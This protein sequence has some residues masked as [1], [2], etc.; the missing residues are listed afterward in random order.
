MYFF[1]SLVIALIAYFV[2]YPLISI[3]SIF[4]TIY[5]LIISI[6]GLVQK[7][8]TVHFSIHISR[9]IVSSNIPILNYI[10]FLLTGIGLWE[11][12]AY[13]PFPDKFYW[14]FGFQIIYVLM[15]EVL[16]R[17]VNNRNHKVKTGWSIFY[18]CLFLLVFFIYITL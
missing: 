17:F 9:L 8:A 1:I 16:S 12:T 5:G 6:I 3:G 14:F 18:P 10:L 13:G 4:I 7:K 15:P 11:P 2:D